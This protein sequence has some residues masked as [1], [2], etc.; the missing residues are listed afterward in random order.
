[1]IRLLSSFARGWPFATI[2]LFVRSAVFVTAAAW[3]GFAVISGGIGSLAGE[4]PV[5]S[6]PQI[7]NLGDLNGKR[8]G[9][10]VG[11][12]LDKAAA[13]VLEQIKINYYEDSEAEI[14]ALHAGEIDAII[15]DQPVVRYYA[16][17]TPEFRALQG[18]LREQR[19]AFA[20]RQ[21]DRELHY[22]VNTALREM[23]GN[24]MVRDLT[25]RWLDDPDAMSQRMPKPSFRGTRGILHFG[26]SPVTPPLSFNNEK[27]EPIGLDIELM[28][29][30]AERI[31]R[32]LVVHSMDFS[33]LVSSLLEGEVDIIGSGFT[34]TRERGK[35]LRFT[36]SYFHS[37]VSA[38]VLSGD[39]SS[40]TAGR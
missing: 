21:D 34:I 35:I 30:L 17:K 11:T 13:E 38:M 3:C 18:V 1:M 28:Q 4:K 27:G 15:D 19:F 29:H 5:S 26:V 16:Q 10:I 32:R 14:R 36:D 37:G 20:L 25:R 40:V 24:G 9:V 23:I 12:I 31:N 8:L 22:A 6:R 39:R 7:S 33:E 2:C